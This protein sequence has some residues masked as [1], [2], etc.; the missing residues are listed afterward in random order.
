ML[1]ISVHYNTRDYTIRIVELPDD[2]IAFHVV[3]EEVLLVE[4]RHPLWQRYVQYYPDKVIY[5]H[6]HSI[7]FVLDNKCR[8]PSCGYTMDDFLNLVI[9][10]GFG[11]PAFFT[12]YDEQYP[13]LTALFMR[14]HQG[15]LAETLLCLRKFILP[16]LVSL[17]MEMVVKL[18][19]FRSK[20]AEFTCPSKLIPKFF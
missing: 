2:T 7:D 6:S 17:T 18:T 13:R 15:N 3:P 9:G 10:G 8:F 19:I 1:G 4:P 20:W 11:T 16:E 5:A 14:K 12:E